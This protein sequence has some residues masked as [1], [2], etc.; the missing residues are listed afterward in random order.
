ML[1]LLSS[2]DDA[3][4]NEEFEQPPVLALGDDKA[5]VMNLVDNDRGKVDRPI[6]RWHLFDIRA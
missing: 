6:R 5:V 4:L 3:G 2:P 1:S